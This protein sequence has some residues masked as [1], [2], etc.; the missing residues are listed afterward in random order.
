MKGMFLI[1]LISSLP[2]SYIHKSLNV[3]S[4]LKVVRIRR[5][6]K[7]INKLSLAEE[8]K[9]YIKILQLIFYLFLYMH[10]LGCSWY[11]IVA[12]IGDKGWIPPLDF[13][14]AGRPEVY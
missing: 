9:A 6:S 1:D 10:L 8:T 2:F 3:L 5:L 7:M 14:W 4:I 11:Y 12:V 13:I